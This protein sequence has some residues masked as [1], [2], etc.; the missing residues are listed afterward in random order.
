MRSATLAAVRLSS[1]CGKLPNHPVPRARRYCM[2]ARPRWRDDARMPLDL[3][4]EDLA[5]AAIDFIASTKRRRR[6]QRAR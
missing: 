3:T 6:S 1:R 5:T 4:G 2:D